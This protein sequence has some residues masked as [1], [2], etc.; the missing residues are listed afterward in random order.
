MFS[1]DRK[2]VQEWCKQKDDLM[3]TGRSAKRQEDPEEDYA[4]VEIVSN[5][6]EP[7]LD[8]Y[9]CLRTVIVARIYAAKP[10]ASYNY[11]SLTYCYFSNCFYCCFTLILAGPWPCGLFN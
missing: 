7:K 9:T 10:I 6:E 1:V 3:A 8:L 5:V 11:L 2:R 4:D